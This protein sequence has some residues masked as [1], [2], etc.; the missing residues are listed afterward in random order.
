MNWGIYFGVAADKINE[1][2]DIPILMKFE[3]S[4]TSI[5]VKYFIDYVEG[6]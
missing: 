1:K 4:G 3:L 2:Y 6:N 5:Q